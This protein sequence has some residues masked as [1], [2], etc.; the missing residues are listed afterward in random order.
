MS[1]AV[2]LSEYNADHYSTYEVISCK[3]TSFALQGMSD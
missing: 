3:Q 1:M 2:A